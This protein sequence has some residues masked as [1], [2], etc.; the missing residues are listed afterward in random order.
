MYGV[1]SAQRGSD[2]LRSDTCG[3]ARGA[4]GCYARS[5]E[6]T[7][8]QYS[9]SMQDRSQRL[10]IVDIELVQKVNIIGCRRLHLVVIQGLA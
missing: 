1:G 9:V 10:T 8:T 3:H 7:R 5:S 2:E 4:K 6:E